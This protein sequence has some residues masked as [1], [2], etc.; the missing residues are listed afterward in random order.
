MEGEDKSTE[1]EFEKLQLDSQ[2][3]QN[4]VDRLKTLNLASNIHNLTPPQQQ[5]DD[6]RREI[7]LV[8]VL[9]STPRVMKIFFELRGLE[10]DPKKKEFIRIVRPIMNIE[11]AYRFCMP[12]KTLYQEVE[13]ASFDEDEIKSL[14]IHFF[15]ENIPYFLL[16]NDNYD[17]NPMDFF[18]VIFTAQTLITAA[19]H[20]AK[21]GKFIN[22]L[23]RTY[24]EGVLRRAL[25]SG[26]TK[27]K[28]SQ[29]FLSK[30]NPF[31][32]RR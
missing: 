19:F 5:Q 4:K 9:S 25:E 6:P 29:G 12:F 22:T 24:D 15:N 1:K 26:D 21:S 17:L 10:F 3:M 13:W 11:G 28:E 8:N 30:Y 7:A 32:E 18:Y 14:Q 27:I 2:K 31:R 16:N 20:K 23:G